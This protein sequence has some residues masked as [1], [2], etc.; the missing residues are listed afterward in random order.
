[1]R[2]FFEK[3]LSGLTNAQAPMEKVKERLKSFKIKIYRAVM[4]TLGGKIFRIEPEFI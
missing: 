1:V 4:K 3:F 2:P